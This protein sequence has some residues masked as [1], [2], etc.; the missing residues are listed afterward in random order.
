MPED[1]V[2]VEIDASEF[3]SF[4]RQ[5]PEEAERVA[6]DY[7]RKGSEVVRD[8]QVGEATDRFGVETSQSRMQHPDSRRPTGRWAGSVRTEVT[9]DHADTGPRVPYRHWVERGSEA[10]PSKIPSTHTGAAFR[11]HRPVHRATKKSRDPL[12]RLL[13]K[14]LE[15]GISRATR[16]AG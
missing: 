3:E 13:N 14:E 16:G 4:A 6:Q 5:A 11:G 9:S 2:E 10:D 12:Q 15:Q 8:K 1:A 7:Y